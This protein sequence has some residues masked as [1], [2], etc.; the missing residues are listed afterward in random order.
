[1]TLSR[2]IQSSGDAEEFRP[3]DTAIFKLIYSNSGTAP[4]TGVKLEE[5]LDEQ[6]VEGQ[7]TIDDGGTRSGALISW[8]LGEVAAGQ[9]GEVSYRVRLSPDLLLKDAGQEFEI[10]NQATL[11]G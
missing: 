7:I 5:H 10:S 3:G 9:V 2:Q 8:D 4:A 11:S 6:I 1:L